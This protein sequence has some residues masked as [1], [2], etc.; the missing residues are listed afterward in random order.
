MKLAILPLLG[1]LEASALGQTYFVNTNTLPPA[2]TTNPP[3]VAIV[4][5][6]AYGNPS[7]D[8]VAPLG[9]CMVTAYQQP[10]SNYTAAA[11]WYSNSGPASV[12]VYIASQANNSSNLL[13][14]LIGAGVDVAATNYY[15]LISPYTG[16]YYTSAVATAQT[17]LTWVQS[18]MAT[19]NAWRTNA[20]FATSNLL[21][22]MLINTYIPTLVNAP[23]NKGGT[24]ASFWK[25]GDG[26]LLWRYWTNGVIQ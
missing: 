26:E 6:I 11:W 23:G 14:Q 18:Q 2:P 25:G 4:N 20:S 9:W 19:N 1:L 16:A 7:W 5:G 24:T 8:Q 10:P 22:V 13:Q 15:S 17:E 12:G 21:Q 3:S